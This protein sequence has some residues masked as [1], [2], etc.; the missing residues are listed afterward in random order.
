MNLRVLL[1]D[2][3]ALIRAGLAAIIDAEADLEV[4]AEAADGVDAVA[5]TKRH[6]PDVVLMDVRM[7]NVDGIEATRQILRIPELSPKIIVVTTFDND[8]YVYEALRAG[9]NG[10]LLKRTPPDDLLAGIRVVARGDALL[11]PAA[12]RRLAAGHTGRS[13]LDAAGLTEREAEVLRLMARGLSNAEIAAR[14]FLS[15]ET[16]KTHVAKIL[17]KLRVRDRTQAVIKAYEAGFVSA[18]G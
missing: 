5:L 9:A 17:A 13:T 10:F 1:A 15:A 6:R 14:L 2:D 12:V 16:V 8:D 4:V 3:E 7:P 18:S 11:F